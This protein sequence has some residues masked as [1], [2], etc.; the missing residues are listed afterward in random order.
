[1]SVATIILAAGQGSRMNSDLPKVMH[2]IAS[3][4]MLGHTMHSAA[5][6]EAKKTVIVV[7]H[8]GGQV[9]KLAHSIADSATI[10]WQKEQNGTGHAVLQAAH[11]LADFEGDV[12]VLYGDTPFVR[13]ETLQAMLA[14]R[15]AGND[16]VVLGF[17]A[18]KP[19]GYGRLIVENKMLK[20]IVEAKDCTDVQKEITF[21]NSGVVC[22]PA[23]LLFS[24]L[25][26]VADNNASG[27]IYLTDIVGIANARNLRCTAI[28]C[29]ESETLGVNSR[30]DL[31]QAE[32]I[33]QKSAR[34]AAME[35]GVTMTAPETVFF[36]HDTVIGRDVTIEP[37]VFFGPDVTVENNVTIKANSHLDGCHISEGAQIG[38][39]AR[40]RPGAEIGGDARVGNFVEIKAA[41]VDRGAKIGHLA[42]VGDA[43]IGEETN[44]GAGVI[45]CNYD[46]VSKHVST[47]G[48][49]VFIGSNSAL[50]SPVHVGD[51]ALIG[52]GSVITKDVPADDLAIARARQDNKKGMGKRLMDRLRSLKAKK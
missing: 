42:Y 40:L 11:A 41:Q 39:F 51:E 31:A 35:N 30:H 13:P 26:D 4:S 5:I 34:H 33:F 46:G 22:A 2:K 3:V 45:F 32:A 18:E 44:I 15:Q 24:L 37:N 8:E 47:I 23:A 17:E 38:P 50:V 21:C 14:A 36:A 20:A 7:G 52:S 49:N 1:M 9:E 48:K 29:P 28:E 6:I 25:A 12:I 43:H 10:V 19:G 16:V 27:E